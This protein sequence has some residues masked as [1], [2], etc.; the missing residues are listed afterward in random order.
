MKGAMMVLFL[1]VCLVLAGSLW[2][3][4]FLYKRYRHMYGTVN[5]VRLDPTGAWVYGEANTSLKPPEAGVPRV[6]YFGDSRVELWQSLPEM[7]GAESIN[8]GISGDT[9][10]QAALRLDRDVIALKPQV[11]V[12]QVGVNDLKSIGVMPSQKQMILDQCNENIGSMVARLREVNVEVVLLTIFPVGA[13]ELSRLPV[14]SEETLVA[15][16][17]ANAFI[18]DLA[19]EGVTVVDSDAVLRKGQRIDAAFALDALHLNGAGYAALSTHIA[20][21]LEELVG[22]IEGVGPADAL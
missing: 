8:R 22:A 2:A 3:N 9:T 14:W 10:T 18:R 19:G 17:G 6:V 11:A 13:I 20:P 16:D 12:F 21:V 4:W 1:V 15:I 7:A 5:A